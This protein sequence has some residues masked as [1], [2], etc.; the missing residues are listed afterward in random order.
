MKKTPLFFRIVGAVLLC[1]VAAVSLMHP[2]YTRGECLDLIALGQL[3]KPYVLGN[4][5][6]DS[7]DCSGLVLDACGCFGVELVHSAQFIGYDDSYAS[8]GD[9]RDLRPGDLIFFDTVSDK[10][11]CD[12]VGL[13]LGMNRFVHASSSEMVVMISEF[14]EKWQG[15]YSWGKRILEPCE[16]DFANEFSDA[17]QAYVRTWI[18]KLLPDGNGEAA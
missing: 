12:H 15:R 16:Q 18:E 3:G 2:M 10:D 8:V 13:W 7:Y 9:P 1:A 17:A 11:L 6:P 14:D 5:G 4:F